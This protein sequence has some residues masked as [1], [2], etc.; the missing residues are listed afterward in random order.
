LIAFCFP[1]VQYFSLGLA[2]LADKQKKDAAF[3]AAS[4][5]FLCRFAWS[6][7]ARND[8]LATIAAELGAK[9]VKINRLC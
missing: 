8:R 7:L 6:F 3:W 4:C 1:L 5:W 9:K 2:V